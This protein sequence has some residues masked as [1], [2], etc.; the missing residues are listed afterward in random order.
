[1]GA[2]A[3]KAAR[4]TAAS[5]RHRARPA[6]RRSRARRRRVLP[7]SA[8]TKMDDDGGQ[9]VLGRVMQCYCSSSD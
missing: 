6:R 3:R 4:H 9:W 1:M 2:P 7:I 8:P 5:A